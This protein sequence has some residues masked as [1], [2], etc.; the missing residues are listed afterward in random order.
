M[1]ME[2]ATRKFRCP[3]C[4][5]KH[6]A[7]LSPMEGHPGMHGKVPCAECHA[8]MWISLNDDGT[9]TAELYEA[10]LHDVYEKKLEAT[11]KAATVN[12]AVAAPPASGGGWLGPVIA[13]AVVAAVVSF[14][15]GNRGTDGKA[16]T[17]AP[18]PGL[19][20]EIQSLSAAVSASEEARAD[21]AKK[22]ASLETAVAAHGVAL[23]TPAAEPAQ[24]A[25]DAGL[26]ELKQKL[27]QALARYADLNGR[28]EGNYTNLRLA[29]KRLEALEEK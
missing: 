6:A 13:A 24:G 25:P 3:K 14:A 19:E 12:A 28:I 20:R 15:L 16:T 4:G 11:V 1:T 9:A 10:H 27:E 26:A 23:T 2:A 22:L 21:L 7:D 18:A 17:A 29:L 5:H 8:L